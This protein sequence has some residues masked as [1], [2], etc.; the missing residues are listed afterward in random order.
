M[1]AEVMQVWEQMNGWSKS[2]LDSMLRLNEIAS[3]A[4]ERLAQQQLA[5]M[6]DC[7]ES[8]LGQMKLLDEAKGVQDVL[9]SQS[10]LATQ[11]G[12]KWMASARKL[13]EISLQ[14]QSELGQW[15]NDRFNQL[16]AQAKQIAEQAQKVVQQEAQK[17]VQT[18]EQA[19]KVVQQEAQKV[20]RQATA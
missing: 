10:K 3:R 1:N 4:T 17:V 6:S 5:V 18:A 19:Q 12:E 13:L 15:M 20:V 8:G 7:F 9:V 2:A 16:N 11:C 14:A